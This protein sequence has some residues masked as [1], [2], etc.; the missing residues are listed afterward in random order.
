MSGPT[1]TLVIVA[2]PGCPRGELVA[3]QW[4]L[5]HVRSRCCWA[6]CSAWV[7]LQCRTASVRADMAAITVG[8]ARPAVTPPTYARRVG[9]AYIRRRLLVGK[10]EPHNATRRSP[11][12]AGFVSHESSDQTAG[13][14]GLLA[15]VLACTTMLRALHPPTHNDDLHRLEAAQ[16][17][18]HQA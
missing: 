5:C 3:A 16:V 4:K 15:T 9:Y 13:G 7:H 8:A 1:G 18:V 17:S 2:A 12:H 10:R 6:S 11:A 14:A